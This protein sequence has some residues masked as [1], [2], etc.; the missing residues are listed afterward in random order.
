MANR[1]EKLKSNDA[2]WVV[3]EEEKCGLIV[4]YFEE[5]F[6]SNRGD[7]RLRWSDW[8]EFVTDK[9]NDNMRNEIT[10]PYSETDVREAV[11]QMCP[12]KAP[13]IDGFSA[14][15]YQKHW[16]LVKG[17]VATQV[18]RMM[19]SMM[20]EDGINKTLITLIPKVKD[21]ESVG[22]FR[23]ISLCNVVIKI[24]TK[25]LANRLKPVIPAIISENQGAFVPVKIIS[26][27]II[28]AQE[29][30]HYIRTRGRQKVGFFALKL[31]ISKAYD[32]VE[33]AFL[34]VMMR[35]LGLPEMW[36]SMVMRCVKTVSY[37]VRVNEL[38]TEEIKPERGIRQG[39][40][41]SPFLFLIC[42][43]WLNLKVKEYQ[44]RRKLKGLKICRSAPEI[45]HML[46]ADDSIFF[47]QATRENAVNLRRILREY[48]EL[49]GQ[50]VILSKSEICF[51]RNVP[52]DER[53][54]ISA[55]LGVKQVEAMS[56]YL[57]LP[58]AFG[59][60]RTELFKDI[61]EKIWKKM[62]GW[63]EKSLSIAGKEVLIKAIVQAMP[64]YAMS[65]FKIPGSLIKRIVS[66][67]TN[68]WWSNCKEGR[69]LHW[70]NY[71]KL[72]RDKMEGGVGFKELA[73]FNDALLSKQIWRLMEKLETLVSKLLKEKYFKAGT[74]LS[75]QVGTRPSMVWRSIWTAGQ[76]VKQWIQ[77]TNDGEEVRWTMESDGKFSTRSAYK[78]LKDL[79]D[80]AEAN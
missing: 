6:R 61:I 18:L 51:G 8:M 35:R 31:D 38:V 29:V 36:I 58:V 17:K 1:I 46:F 49:S 39:D 56:K 42:S 45:T 27:N 15:F 70:C 11:F 57:G 65:C 71:K 21:P 20:L 37:V 26:D 13:V 32:R 44:R 69:G 64:T 7:I 80:R 63:K 50:K 30:I 22:E 2:E 62:Q 24:V 47:L 74:P 10:R 3:E 33:W 75:C 9:L 52:E 43:E 59:N 77:T 67:I 72:C 73:I 53:Q 5:I 60:N 28:A 55:T 19:N 23:P 14:L 4:K 66:M 16:S 68:F 25:M 76:K 34:E 12:T 41:L 54:I 48:E 78:A 40:P 79:S